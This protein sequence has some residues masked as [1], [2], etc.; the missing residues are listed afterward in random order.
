MTFKSEHTLVVD[1]SE[2]GYELSA[3]AVGSMVDEAQERV[4]LRRLLVVLDPAPGV[5]RVVMREACG[6]VVRLWNDGTTLCACMEV[7][8]NERGKALAALS[9]EEWGK[10]VP[11]LMG[12]A[13]GG[14]VQ[15]LPVLYGLKLER[16]APFSGGLG[17][18]R[19][20]GPPDG[21]WVCGSCQWYDGRT[22]APAKCPA[23]GGLSEAATA[24]WPE[25]TDQCGDPYPKAGDSEGVVV[26]NPD[27]EGKVYVRVKDEWEPRRGVLVTPENREELLGAIT[28]EDCD[29]GLILIDGKQAGQDAI[30]ALTPGQ[31][32]GRAVWKG[33]MRV[34]FVD[35]RTD[36]GGRTFDSVEELE[37]AEED[38]RTERMAEAR[39]RDAAGGAPPSLADVMTRAA[40]LILGATVRGRPAGCLLHDDMEAGKAGGCG[41][42][43]AFLSAVERPDPMKTALVAP[44]A[45]RVYVQEPWPED[46]WG[47]VGVGHGYADVAEAHAAARGELF[48]V[49]GLEPGAY[50]R[51]RCDGKTLATAYVPRKDEERPVVLSRGGRDYSALGKKARAAKGATLDEAPIG[52]EAWWEEQGLR[53]GPGKSTA[54]AV[55]CAGRKALWKGLREEREAQ[56]HLTIETRAP[57]QEWEKVH[58]GP[59]L[60]KA[61]HPDL[62]TTGQAAMLL[63]VLTHDVR[64]EMVA[65]GLAMDSVAAVLERMYAVVQRCVGES[66]E[67]EHH[68][69]YN[70]ALNESWDCVPKTPTRERTPERFAHDLGFSAGV[71]WLY[72]SQEANATAKRLHVDLLTSAQA[73]MLLRVLLHD[74]R[75]DMVAQ[76]LALDTVAS[77]LETATKVVGRC[78]AD[79]PAARYKATPPEVTV[80]QTETCTPGAWCGD[81]EGAWCEIHGDDPAPGD[82]TCVTPN[83][84]ARALLGSERCDTHH[85]GNE[86]DKARQREAAVANAEY[87]AWQAR[88]RGLDSPREVHQEA[89]AAGV[90]WHHEVNC[91][92]VVIAPY[93]P[94]YRPPADLRA[95]LVKL[96]AGLPLDSPMLAHDLAYELLVGVAKLVV[97][98]GST[99]DRTEV[100]RLV[101]ATAG[102]QQDIYAEFKPPSDPKTTQVGAQPYCHAGRDGDCSWEGCPQEH[103]ER[104]SHCALGAPDCP[105]CDGYMKMGDDDLWRCAENGCKGTLEPTEATK[106]A[107]AAERARFPYAGYT[108]IDPSSPMT[109]GLAPYAEDATPVE[110]FE[111][112]SADMTAEGVKLRG[113]A[114]K[115]G[116]PNKNRRVYA[117]RKMYYYRCESCG[118][119][120]HSNV[121]PERPTICLRGCPGVMV[122]T[123]RK[124]WAEPTTD[125]EVKTAVEEL[126]A[127]LATPER[128]A[129]GL[130]HAVRMREAV[131]LSTLREYN[132]LARAKEP[133]DSC[134]NHNM[135]SGTCHVC[136][137]KWGSCAKT[138]D[139]AYEECMGCTSERCRGAGFLDVKLADGKMGL[140]CSSCVERSITL[141]IE[142][143]HT[144]T[145]VRLL[146]L[147]KQIKSGVRS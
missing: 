85:A 64:A 46:T 36:R 104:Q 107:V 81:G 35:P 70:S 68:V 65:S 138:Y 143:E 52:F 84:T 132:K 14:L 128:M 117:G 78:V 83:C 39:A 94:L 59:N 19:V 28:V 142:R 44:V 2:K 90:K 75:A 23:C 47:P 119:G 97:A 50:Y 34:G 77:V 111:P 115:L 48:G 110:G 6:V 1:C 91:V 121:P 87:G 45:G 114:Q 66:R 135:P 32:V 72:N 120:E 146:N 51:L 86:G 136:G 140:L 112:L 8:L 37:A 95:A 21:T 10:L 82:G 113:V 109:I 116:E 101:E 133:C 80:Y 9:D 131:H 89:F 57:G 137:R 126:F 56:G 130:S 69:G 40:D 60:V 20:S 27:D 96:E 11:G 61:Q 123:T 4:E 12:M 43:A 106:A 100:R 24:G 144:L 55:W 73:A 7:L 103:G 79:N 31:R 141:A 122:E 3:E 124:V 99:W 105:E 53:L 5:G 98:H 25:G 29:G 17:F 74:L 15:V 30:L 129:A 54:L 102:L 62:L 71:A 88:K 49:Q 22:E 139:A 93:I 125:A 76:G 42:C 33:G 16:V 26:A 41:S 13:G 67:L 145:N 38:E 127:R 118:L 63:K 18:V 147:A 134:R 58:E 92:P 108:E